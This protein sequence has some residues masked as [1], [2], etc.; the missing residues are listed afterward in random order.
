M[1]IGFALNSH[2]AIRLLNRFESGFSVDAPLFTVVKCESSAHITAYAPVIFMMSSKC[3]QPLDAEQLPCH[4]AGVVT[5]CLLTLLYKHHATFALLAVQ[6]SM[7]V[8]NRKA[9]VTE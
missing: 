2:W 5:R 8:Y 7:L 4:N 3:R 9:I 1:R 6:K